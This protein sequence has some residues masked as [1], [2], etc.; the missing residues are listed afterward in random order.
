M[1]QPPSPQNHFL[2]P[3]PHPTPLVKMFL[4]QQPPFPQ[5]DFHFTRHYLSCFWSVRKRGREMRL[6]TT[7]FKRWKGEV[8][9]L[10]YVGGLEEGLDFKQLASLSH[11]LLLSNLESIFL[12]RFLDIFPMVERCFWR[13]GGV[14]DIKTKE[15]KLQKHSLPSCLICKIIFSTF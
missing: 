4:G 10:P 5:T 1:G 9:V 8:V 6:W 15:T 7:S 2:L 11:H 14:R 13:R 12:R 3:P